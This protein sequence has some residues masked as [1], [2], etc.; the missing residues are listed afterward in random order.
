[1][2]LLV[3]PFIETIGYTWVPGTTAGPTST[4]SRAG[5]VDLAV[6]AIPSA[7]ATAS[8]V[9]TT[10]TQTFTGPK[11]FSS[12]L[13]FGAGAHPNYEVNLDFGSDVANTWR[14]IVDATLSTAQFSSHGFI[15]DVVDAN[16]N[17]AVPNSVNIVEAERYYVAMVRTESTT[18]D[19]PDAC[20][21]T[22]P[23]NRIRAIKTAVGSYEIQIQNEAQF[24]EYKVSI[25]TYASNGSHT[26]NYYAGTTAGTAIATYAA[27]VSTAK[28]WF[29]EAK[30]AATTASTTTT[31]G[32]LTVAGGAGIAGQLTVGNISATTTIVA[33]SSITGTEL[34]TSTSGATGTTRLF[35]NSPAGQT[36]SLGRFMVNGTDAF[37]IAANGATTVSG[38]ALGGTSGNTVALQ[39]LNGT[40]GNGAA[41]ETILIRDATG[42]DWTTAGTRIQQKVDSSFMAWQ[43]FNG[44]GNQN[45]IAWGTGA[46]TGA[47]TDIAERMRLNA[48]G[49]LSLSANI[50]ST[51]TTTG[52]VVITGGLGVSGQITAG[53]SII[54]ASIIGSPNLV[55]RGLGA[56]QEGGQLVLGYGNNLATTITGQAN[57]TWNVDVASDQSFRIFRQNNA[58]TALTALTFTE[59]TATATFGGSVG[60]GMAPALALDVLGNIRGTASI[61]VNSPTGNDFINT[62]ST[63]NLR[64]GWNTFGV[65][66]G[67]AVVGTEASAPLLLATG[68]TERMRIATTGQVSFNANIASS[69]TTSG[70]LAVTGG[71][72]LTGA[73][74]AGSHVVT[75]GNAYINNISPTLFMQDTDNTSAMLHVNSNLI[76]FLRGNGVNSAVW[77]SGPNGRHPM[78]L[79]LATGDVTF[80]GDVVAFSDAR[81]KKNIQVIDNA[82][83][84]VQSLRGVTFEHLEQGRGTGLIAQ[85]LQAV[86]PEAVKTAK[87]GKGDE[88]LT[89]AYGNTIGLLVEAIKELKA[90]IDAL[91]AAKQ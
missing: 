45:G 66:I 41:L 15:I 42:T 68:S 84:K 10:G 50:A 71:I 80:S 4:I 56:G 39:S 91:K 33:G 61:T 67:N 65:G 88:Y 57:N 53:G 40:T 51:S 77:D 60:I 20:Y 63:G 87:D 48:S 21:V 38:G 22:G 9:V 16:G 1:M 70:T 83:E 12:G 54:G 30:I 34:A 43:Q 17:H 7:S 27:T 85:E 2:G 14:K 28:N 46:S 18:L 86:L 62:S 59:A 75:S 44:N 74:Y 89:V 58:G 72:G 79:D 78:M 24:R 32:A 35:I 25:S 52:T 90:E 23:G 64:M 73:L 37:S 31:T 11:L 13:A 76:Y 82:L 81:L 3:T 49:V 5:Q 36:A 69:S 19:T 6:A 55:S 8:G 29:Q 47:R 26:I